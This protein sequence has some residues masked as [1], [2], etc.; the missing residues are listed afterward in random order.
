M[1]A[2]LSTSKLEFKSE[3]LKTSARQKEVGYLRRICSSLREAAKFSEPELR[4]LVVGLHRVA[5][6]ARS[7]VRCVIHNARHDF[8]AALGYS[9]KAD[10]RMADIYAG[11][12]LQKADQALTKLAYGYDITGE[13]MEPGEQESRSPNLWDQGNSPK[14]D[15]TPRNPANQLV[16]AEAESD[17]PEL[18]EFKHKRIQFPPRTR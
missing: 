9:K 16:D 5:S 1:S 7:D 17:Y 18:R 11:Y 14:F 15:R 12:A 6:L 13:V 4:E 2:R 10:C 3:L 8:D